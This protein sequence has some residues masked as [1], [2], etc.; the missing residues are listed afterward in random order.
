M[1]YKNEKLG[2]SFELP[3]RPTVRQQLAFYSTLRQWKEDPPEVQCWEA[4]KKILTHWECAALPDPL[5]SL[6][7]MTNPTQVRV[8]TW[9]GW[10]L[11]GH[12]NKLEDLDPN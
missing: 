10:T 7:E 5:T 3:D 9:A 12:F 4:G 11:F 1:E 6:D 8:I 2:C